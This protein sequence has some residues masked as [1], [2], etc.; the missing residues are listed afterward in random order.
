MHNYIRL[1]KKKNVS[2]AQ[3]KFADGAPCRWSRRKSILKE[4][5]RH[6]RREVNRGWGSRFSQGERDGLYS[7]RNEKA[8][9]S[10]FRREEGDVGRSR[11]VG[12]PRMG[13]GI[14]T[15]VKKKAK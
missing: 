9:R 10:S 15:R 2:V 11:R 14:M 3:E 6:G 12:G 5:A 7:R 4:C 13:R 1:G 8:H